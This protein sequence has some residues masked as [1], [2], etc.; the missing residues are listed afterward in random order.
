MYTKRWSIFIGAIAL[1]AAGTVCAGQKD[2]RPEIYIVTI[3]NT[4]THL[5]IVGLDGE[6]K[7]FFLKKKL[8][9]TAGPHQVQLQTGNLK[10]ADGADNR[11]YQGKVQLEFD[12]KDDHTYLFGMEPNTWGI[13][14]DTQVCVYEEPTDDPKA[15]KS[16]FREFRHPGPNAQK[17]VCTRLNAEPI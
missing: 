3:T 15:K 13:S 4:G 8:R 10:S 2:R 12:T 1:M 11:T 14:K 5:D 16:V 9:V 17:I 6:R 7:G